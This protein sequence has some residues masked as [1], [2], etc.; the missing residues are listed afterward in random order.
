[1]VAAIGA[2]CGIVRL[3]GGPGVE[4]GLLE[5]RMSA[6]VRD[7]VGNITGMVCDGAKAGCAL[8]VATAAATA[9]QSAMLALQGLAVASTDGIIDD[10]IEVTLSN[11]AAIGREGMRETDSMVLSMMLA[12][13]G[14]D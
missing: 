9:V 2:A 6:V 12:K 3:L 4:I 1:M 11:L 5:Q 13:S 10:D 7:M 14:R 8:K